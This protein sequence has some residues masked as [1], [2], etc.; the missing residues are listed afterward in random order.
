MNLRPGRGR[1]LEEKIKWALRS[2]RSERKGR[3][4]GYCVETYNVDGKET[5][6]LYAVCYN[7]R[8][9][10]FWQLRA[11]VLHGKDMEVTDGKTGVRIF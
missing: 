4:G 3:P 8:Q 7:L 5:Y 11:K 1:S 6:E 10:R 2:L 9:A